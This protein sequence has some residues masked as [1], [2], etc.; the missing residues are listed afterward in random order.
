MPLLGLKLHWQILIALLLAA[1][2]GAAIRLAGV[3]DSSFAAGLTATCDFL[4][5]LFMNALRMIMVPL[6]MSTVIVGMLTIGSGEDFGRLGLKTLGYYLLTSA[7]AVLTGLVL[8]NVIGPGR[9]SLETAQAIVGQAQPADELLGSVAGRGAGD[10]V[11]IFLRMVPPNVFEA[12]A[13][14]GQILGIIV[15]SLLVGFFA[16]TLPL[17]HRATQSAFWESAQALMMKLTDFVI[18]FAPIGVFGLVTPIL[19]RTGFDLF[20]P[21]SLFFLTVLAGPCPAD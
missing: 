19:V 4:G 15:I 18:A 7:M 20:R 1:A 2:V 5:T 9:V 11:D 17:H 13:D 10:M 8:V 16:S 12:A 6:I 3:H 21:L 14:N